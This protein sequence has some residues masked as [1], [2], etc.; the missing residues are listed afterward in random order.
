MFFRVFVFVCVSD[1]PCCASSCPSSSSPLTNCFSSTHYRP[2]PLITS[3][4]LPLLPL[5]FEPP[6]FHPFNDSFPSLT[7]LANHFHATKSH[8]SPFTPT[9]YPSYLHSAYATLIV[10]DSS[11]CVQMYRDTDPAY[12]DP[13]STQYPTCSQSPSDG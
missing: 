2:P 3:P 5:P 9:H 6:F 8:P 4:T 11:P 12:W 7:L 1:I 13:C 10:I